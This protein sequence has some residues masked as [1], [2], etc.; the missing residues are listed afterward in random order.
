MGLT[1]K[2]LVVCTG[3]I[4]RSPMGEIVLSAKLAELGI[5]NVAVA[6]AA[7]S[8]EEHGNPVDSRAQRVLREA[9]YTIPPHAAHRATAKELQ[10]ADLVLA[11]T[12]GHALALRRMM[13]S[14]GADLAKLHLWREYD[15]TLSPSPEGVFGRSGL[16]EQTGSQTGSQKNKPAVHSEYYSS[17]GKYDVPDP[18]YG[19]QEGFYDTLATI[20]RGAEGIISQLK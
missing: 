13:L 5:K 14:A 2:I 12:V 11:M 16:L 9:G 20:E 8:S 3:N 17:D 7:V 4:C 1:Y 6:S 15:G 19:G 10:E 18:W